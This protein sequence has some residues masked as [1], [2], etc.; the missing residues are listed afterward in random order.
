MR[1][2]ARI[3]SNRDKYWVQVQGFFGKGILSKSELGYEDLVRYGN[4][5]AQGRR[6]APDLRI[7]TRVRAGRGARTSCAHAPLL[8]M[9][10]A[11]LTLALH[12]IRA[13]PYSMP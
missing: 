12:P 8:C 13:L 6:T 4:T 5:K 11:S 3:T 7:R 9:H 2:P 1:G 10:I